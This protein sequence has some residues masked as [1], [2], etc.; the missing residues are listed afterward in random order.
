MYTLY[1]LQCADK[2]LY[3][4]ITVEMTRRLS[5]HNSSARGA[6]YTRARRPV[7]LRYTKLFKNRSLASRAEARVKKMTRKE[8]L[9][10]LNTPKI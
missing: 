6:K 10:L 8:K 4:G 7:A 2:T 1:I 9:R 3:T 5:E